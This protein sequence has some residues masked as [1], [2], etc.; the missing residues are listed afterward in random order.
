MNYSKLQAP[1]RRGLFLCGMP[2]GRI[3]KVG[4][5]LLLP[6]VMLQH[7]ARGPS[8]HSSL[9][10]THKAGVEAAPYSGGRKKLCPTVGYNSPVAM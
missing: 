8:Y 7:D 5:P 6:N 4:V 1:L 3:E 10:G 9:A 2:R